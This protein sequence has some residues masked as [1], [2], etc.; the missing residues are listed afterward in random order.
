MGNCLRVCAGDDSD[1]ENTTYQG[2]QGSYGS[3]EEPPHR[4]IVVTLDGY[5]AFTRDLQEFK[6][7][8]KLPPEL[9]NW[10]SVSKRH[11][12]NW[13][14]MLLDA[15]DTTRPIPATAGQVRVLIIRTLEGRIHGYELQSLL[16]FYH[17]N[18]LPP[19]PKKP[20]VPQVPQEPQVPKKPHVKQEPQVPK[21]P[22]VKQEP[23]P[24][25]KPQ[26]S[27]KPERPRG[28]KY[29][30]VEP[31]VEYVIVTMPI[32][33]NCVGDG[34]GFTA[35]VEVDKDS[36]E[37]YQ[38]PEEIKDNVKKR[39]DALARHDT[40]TVN[41]M[42]NSMRRS[43]YKVING[44]KLVR[45]YRIRLKGVDAPELGQPFGDEAKQILAEIVQDC[46]LSIQVYY[47]DIYDRE[48]GDA[49]VCDTGIFVQE[50]LL[51]KGAAH[52]HR[53]FDCRPNFAK[54]EA[55]ARAARV[56][57]WAAAHIETPW[58]YKKKDSQKRNNRGGG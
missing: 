22:H 20:Q 53:V 38:L 13:Y 29:P 4:P 51:K 26:V 3:F 31:D 17:L 56:G 6:T 41:E 39:R 8:K 43:G 14:Q 9:S 48:V 33:K 23:Q 5:S 49:Y 35:F 18:N 15:W 24:S 7:T 52:H 19:E 55:A 46:K 10:V 42:N 32:K 50:E 44:H 25:R 57:L 37:K 40:A 2:Y 30:T 27:Q 34:D 36:R 11:Q 16:Q 45:V 1:S 21:K 47:K 12:T 28:T 54:W 58:D